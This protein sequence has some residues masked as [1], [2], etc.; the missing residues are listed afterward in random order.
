MICVSASKQLIS[1]VLLLLVVLFLWGMFFNL[2]NRIYSIIEPDNQSI[3][4][5]IRAMEIKAYDMFAVKSALMSAQD[6]SKA[7]TQTDNVPIISLSGDLNDHS[8]AGRYLNMFLGYVD[9]YKIKNLTMVHGKIR[10]NQ[11]KLNTSDT[12]REIFAAE[13]RVEFSSFLDSDTILF[14]TKMLAV[15]PGYLDV[16]NLSISRNTVVDQH[17]VESLNARSNGDLSVSMDI[18]WYADSDSIANIK[19]LKL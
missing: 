18:I 9:E 11:L 8:R 4:E 19:G 14:I 1:S 17:Y 10:E 12:A 13:L 2:Q 6:I 3:A 16:I 15:I 5:N 7:L